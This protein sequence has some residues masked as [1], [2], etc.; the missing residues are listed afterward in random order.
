[1]M[2]ATTS[3]LAAILLANASLTIA[4]IPQQMRHEHSL[5]SRYHFHLY[6]SISDDE[7]DEPII[8]H[9]QNLKE[10]ASQIDVD[11]KTTRPRY[12][13]GVGKNMP[14]STQEDVQPKNGHVDLQS[15]NACSPVS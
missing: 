2:V 7:D 14:I 5:W 13:L 6:A 9:T 3:L 12:E 11:S 10:L 1:M 4:F 8:S 15:L